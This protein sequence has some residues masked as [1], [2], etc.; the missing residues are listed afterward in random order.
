MSLACHF[1]IIYALIIKT[2]LPIRQTIARGR[3]LDP[4]ITVP[5]HDF[6]DAVLG[7]SVGQ[8]YLGHELGDECVRHPR[9]IGYLNVGRIS[10]C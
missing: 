7:L 10:H 1:A 4:K 3:E 5:A 8:G 9:V 6:F 2:S